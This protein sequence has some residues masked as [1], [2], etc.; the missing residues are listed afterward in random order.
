MMVIFA[1]L[2]KERKGVA[3]HYFKLNFSLTVSLLPRL[4]VPEDFNLPQPVQIF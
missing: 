1:H 4:T 2:A 3:S